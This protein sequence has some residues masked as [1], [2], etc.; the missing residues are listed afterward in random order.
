[1]SLWPFCDSFVGYDPLNFCN[2]PQ[3]YEFKLDTWETF[4]KPAK[5]KTVEK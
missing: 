2:G 5:N 3:N 1:M 4:G